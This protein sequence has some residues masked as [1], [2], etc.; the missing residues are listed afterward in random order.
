M[1]NKNLN[2]KWRS[3]DLPKDIGRHEAANIILLCSHNHCLRFDDSSLEKIKIQVHCQSDDEYIQAEALLTQAIA[4]ELLR[5]EIRRN[6][7]PEIKLLVDA[8]LAQVSRK[9]S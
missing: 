8:V 2:G 5:K 9:H 6:N 1:P 4:D 3:I 7:D